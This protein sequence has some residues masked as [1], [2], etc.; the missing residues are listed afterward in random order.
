MLRSISLTLV[1]AFPGL[2]FAG[3]DA[4]KSIEFFE[5]KIRPVLVT[6]CYECHSAQSKK[7]KAQLLL[8][9]KEGMRRGA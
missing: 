7:L 4:P 3:D 1:L 2:S 5:K 8:D 9:T 6:H